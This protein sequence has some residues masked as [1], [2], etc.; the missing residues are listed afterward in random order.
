MTPW[1]LVH[2]AP[3]SLG[4]SGPRI[5]EWVALSTPGDLPNPWI[6]FAS[7]ESPALAGGFF[8]I[9][10]TWDVSCKVW[11]QTYA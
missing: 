10:A 6:E 1:T 8:T 4:F 7:P 9:T 5:L 2:Q 11:G 3:L